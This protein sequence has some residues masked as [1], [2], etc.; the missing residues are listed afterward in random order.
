MTSYRPP[1]TPPLQDSTGSR[2]YICIRIP[3]G[4]LI[5]NTG[6]IDYGQL[7]AQVVYELQVLKAPYW[8]NDE[9]VARIQQLN[10]EFMEQKDIAEIIMACFRKPKEDEVVKTMNSTEMLKI[11]QREY[12]SVPSTHGTKVSIGTGVQ[13][14]GLWEVYGRSPAKTSRAETPINKGISKGYGRSDGF[15]A[16][17]SFIRTQ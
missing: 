12:P 7:Y 9:E 15:F 5:D 13:T 3:D 10:Q 17:I 4:Q 6:E 8:F 11:I 16:C 2:R 1:V 14:G